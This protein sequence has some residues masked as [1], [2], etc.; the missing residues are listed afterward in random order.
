MFRHRASSL[1][2]TRPALCFYY[3]GSAAVAAAALAGLD[4]AGSGAVHVLQCLR[5]LRE[6]LGW[7]AREQGR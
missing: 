2:A 3:G 1:V 5:V 6:H 4:A 7:R